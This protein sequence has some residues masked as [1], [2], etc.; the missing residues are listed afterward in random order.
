MGEVVSV[1]LKI[2]IEF[3]AELY[4]FYGLVGFK[5]ERSKYFILKL[6]L[7]LAAV[8]AVAFGVA[9]FYWLFGNTVWGRIIVYL[10]L[11]GITTLHFRLCFNENYKTVLFCCLLAYAA[12]NI[13]YKLFLILWCTGEQ[14]GLFDSW[15]SLFELYYRLLYYTFFIAVTAGLYFL[16]IRRQ[17]KRLSNSQINNRML[18]IAFSVLLITVVLC[19]CEDIYFAELSELKENRYSVYEYFALRQTGNALSVVC[20]AVVLLLIVKS[21]EERDLKRE[22]EY[23]QYTVRQS[24]RQYEISKDT[25]DMINIKCHDIKYKL[26]SFVNGGEYSA[27]AVDDLRKSI[28]IYDSK[29]ETG[30]KILD[31]LFT[32][33]SLYCEQNG[34]S[35]SCMADGEKLAFISD[36]DLYCLFGNILDNALEA[37]NSISEKERRIINIVIKVKNGMLIIQEEN[38]FDGQL[39]FKDGLPQTIKDDK[40]Y[41]GFGMRSIKMIVHKYDGELTASVADDIFHLNIIFSLDAV[42][43]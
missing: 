14:L 42:K 36:G 21:V 43:N 6:F 39:D 19:S 8:L 17:S 5:L 34:I 11:F 32:E 3:L 35:F 16:L 24:E 40:N 29:I 41:H 25:I 22:V 23:L 20:C 15:G 4:I 26:G 27:S 2:I 38:Y 7:G 1:Y 10:F 37:V 9:Y 30:N 18:A 33:K 13:V 12:Q 31:V 28:S